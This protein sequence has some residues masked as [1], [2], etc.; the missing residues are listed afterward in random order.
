M[1]NRETR[2]AGNQSDQP[3]QP[4]QPNKR[5][6]DKRRFSFYWIYAI[7][8][9]VLIGLQFYGRDTITP[10]DSML[11]SFAPTGDT[12]V[13]SIQGDRDNNGGAYIGEQ[14]AFDRTLTDQER[15]YLM[16][17]F[18][19][20]I[21]RNDLSEAA[22]G[23]VAYQYAMYGMANVPSNFIDEA[24]QKM[25]NDRQQVERLSEQVAEQKVIAAV[26]DIISFDKKSISVEKFR[27]LK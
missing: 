2:Q 9:A 8:F 10:T 7:L 19:L 17:K 25:L 21:D 14:I 18:D 24:A 13:N 15:D 23:Y 11:M 27:E 12:Y 4:N 20:K 26:K 6:K 16:K 5:P 1:N 22:H 3:S